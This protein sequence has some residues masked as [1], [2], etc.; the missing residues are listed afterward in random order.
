MTVA[1]NSMPVTAYV[2]MQLP[3][4]SNCSAFAEMRKDDETISRIEK[5]DREKP[6]PQNK[7]TLR[8]LLS[9]PLRYLPGELIV[10]V[11]DG[12]D[13]VQNVFVGLSV[14]AST[15]RGT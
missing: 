11:I 4:S 3:E 8:K 13:D 7:A 14:R 10:A 12:N 2:L 6:S 5:I 9:K 1:S 15:M